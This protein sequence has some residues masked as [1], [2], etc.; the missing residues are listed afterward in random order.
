MGNKSHFLHFPPPFSLIL[1]TE[2]LKLSTPDT[3]LARNYGKEPVFLKDIARGENISEKYLSL[4]IILLCG[5][6]LV[7]SVRRAYGGYNLACRGRRKPTQRRFNQVT[8]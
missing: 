7:S 4:I 6:G 1:Y 3:A 8:C 5:I 2:A